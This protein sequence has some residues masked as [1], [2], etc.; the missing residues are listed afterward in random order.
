M[1]VKS[2]KMYNARDSWKTKDAFFTSGI[3]IININMKC[4]ITDLNF[5]ITIK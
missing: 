2:F 5:A 1:N 4:R 3:H